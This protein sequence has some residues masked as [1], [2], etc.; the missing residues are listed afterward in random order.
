MA[1]LRLLVQGGEECIPHVQRQKKDPKDPRPRSSRASERRSSV[2]TA[3]GKGGSI[4]LIWQF[5]GTS[6]GFFWKGNQLLDS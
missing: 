2:T 4:G 6:W 1:Q 5:N 3:I